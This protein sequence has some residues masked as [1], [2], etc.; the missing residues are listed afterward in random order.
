MKLNT[1]HIG[2][3]CEAMVIARLVQAGCSVLMPFGD[4]QR[5]DM[6]VEHRKKLGTFLRIQCKTG[7]L[8]N[9]VII[10]KTSSH[11]RG[12]GKTRSYSGE[13]D[14]FGVYCPETDS[15]YMIP[16]RICGAS[17][18]YLRVGE[19]KNGQAERINWASDYLFA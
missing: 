3:T 16:A 8:R 10:F 17:S 15:V 9:D 6:L 2:D 5:Y 4:N 13:V 18:M 19:S 1:K 7:R 14:I 11:T 12:T